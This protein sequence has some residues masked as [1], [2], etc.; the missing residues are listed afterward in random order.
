MWTRDK[1]VVAAV[2]ENDYRHFSAI[3]PIR[4]EAK[5]APDDSAEEEVDC[6]THGPDNLCFRNDIRGEVRDDT[7]DPVDQNGQSSSGHGE[8]VADIFPVPHQFPPVRVGRE[9]RVVRSYEVG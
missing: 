8:I 7:D 2:T 1:R 4:D 9:A 5:A 6:P 3:H